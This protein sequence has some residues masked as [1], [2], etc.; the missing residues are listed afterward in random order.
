MQSTKTPFKKKIFSLLLALSICAISFLPYLHDLEFFAGKKG[1]SGFSSLRIGTWV[2]SLFVFGISGWIFAFIG[3][4]GKLY[5]F[6]ILAPIFMG[7]F[8]LFIYVLDKRKTY[9]NDFNWKVILNF[10]IL[11]VI[12]VSYYAIKLI[13]PKK[14][15]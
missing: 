13:P 10:S 8:Q 14:N 5:R 15:E 1:F 11:L 6:V 4:K 12:I 3:N 7:L 2:V 9:I